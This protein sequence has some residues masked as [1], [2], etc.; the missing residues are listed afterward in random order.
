MIFSSFMV[1]FEI[2]A[3]HNHEHQDEYRK[4]GVVEKEGSRIRGQSLRVSGRRR[5]TG[6]VRGVA[7]LKG[8]KGIRGGCLNTKASEDLTT[9]EYGWL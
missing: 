2:K 4:N 7:G 6:E 1:I 5:G 9:D 3:N 8:R